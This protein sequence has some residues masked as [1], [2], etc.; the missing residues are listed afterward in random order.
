MAIPHWWWRVTRCDEFSVMDLPSHMEVCDEEVVNWRSLPLRGT[1]WWFDIPTPAK[2]NL[3]GGPSPTLLETWIHS[4]GSCW[5]PRLDLSFRI[6]LSGFM[7]EDQHVESWWYKT[8]P[9]TRL[10]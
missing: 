2:I 1:W 6:G 4:S 10:R 7:A 3:I 9:G 5:L 8:N